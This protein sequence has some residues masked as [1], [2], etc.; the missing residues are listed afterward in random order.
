MATIRLIPSAYSVSSSNLSVS[1]ATNMYNN[2]DNTTY[3]TFTSPTGSN[4]D[5]YYL[6]INGFNFS[7]VPTGATITSFTVKI[8]CYESNISTNATYRMYLCNGTTATTDYASTRPSTS[9]QTITFDNVSSTYDTLSGYGSDFG[10]RLSVRNSTSTSEGILYVYGAEILVNYSLTGSVVSTTITGGTMLSDANISVATGSSHTI[11]FKT[12]DANYDILSMT[13]NG[14]AVEPVGDTYTAYTVATTSNA[15]YTVST[16]YGTYDGSISDTIDGDTSTY[17]WSNG[18]QTSGNYVLI[19]FSDLIRLNSFSTYSSN[20][21]DYPQSNNV[22][23][24]STDGENWE[25]I[26]TFQDSQTSTFS[27]LTNTYGKYI[28]IYATSTINYW[29]VIAEITIDYNDATSTTM[30]CYSYTIP[31]VDAD[32]A[33]VITCGLPDAALYLKTGE[34]TWRRVAKIYK[35][36]GTK[37]W[38]EVTPEDFNTFAANKKFMQ[39]EIPSLPVGSIS[40]STNAINITEDTLAADTYTLYYEDENNNKLDGWS[41]IG[42]ITKS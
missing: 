39:L 35:K 19:T 1:N 22:L 20:A 6:Y 34:S 2:T 42:T 12:D 17:W 23:Q 33:I 9:V 7:D 5:T 10:I 8:K 32:T 38:E 4:Y 11:Y 18:S 30:N 21:S 27:N 29:L 40:N 37:T 3:A 28:R 16:N 13:A 36:T 14:T 41:A 26:G 24:I 25:N 31:S 15:T